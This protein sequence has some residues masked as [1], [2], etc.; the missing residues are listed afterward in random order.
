MILRYPT[1]RPLESYFHVKLH[2]LEIHL[3]G[4]V[5]LDFICTSRNDSPTLQRPDKFAIFRLQICPPIE[6]K[7][8]RRLDV[9]GDGESMAIDSRKLNVYLEL[10][11][12]FVCYSLKSRL[13]VLGSAVPMTSAPL[14]SDSNSDCP[15]LC[16]MDTRSH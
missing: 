16:L 2:L 14:R 9:S 5:E 1:V 11:G 3:F 13:V 4:I 8:T 6:D 15:N 12:R 7:F 10:D